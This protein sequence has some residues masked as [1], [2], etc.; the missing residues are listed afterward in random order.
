MNPM[1][2]LRRD[3]NKVFGIRAA[4]EAK[5][6]HQEAARSAGGMKQAH[7][8]AAKHGISIDKDSAGGWWVTHPK[9]SGDADPLDG[10]NFCTDGREVLEAVRCYADHMAKT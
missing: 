6:K 5:V 8:L 1:Q 3:M 4:A 7:A 2:A 10:A 9:L